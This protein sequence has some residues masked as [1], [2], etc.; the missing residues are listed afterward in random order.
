[1][2][3][4]LDQLGLGEVVRQTF[5]ILVAAVAFAL[6]LAF[7]LGGRE[8]A[9]DLLDRWLD[10]RGRSTDKDDRPPPL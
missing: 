2:L 3:I 4:A 8:R 10:G 1:V 7:G 6:A 5:L 9:A